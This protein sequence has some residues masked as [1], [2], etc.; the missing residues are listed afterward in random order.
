MAVVLLGIVRVKNEM[1]II[2]RVDVEE[3]P[4]TF[5]LAYED[6]SFLSRDDEIALKGWFFPV[7]DSYR[8]VILV[9]GV[10]LHRADPS[11]GMLNIA[12]GLVNFGFNVLTFDLR[13]HG[14]S[15]GN[16]RY[17]GH[18]EKRDLHG[19]IDYI[20]KRAFSKIGVL[21]F[22]MGAATA[23]MT[24]AESDDIDAIV[25]DS[26]FADVKDIIVAQFK[27][28]TGLPRFMMR[29]L[30]Q[31]ARLFYRINFLA[32]KPIESLAE[33]GDVPVFFIHG[34]QD[35]TIPVEHARRMYQVSGNTKNKL[36][37]TP[38]VKHMRSYASF[39]TEYLKKVTAFFDSNLS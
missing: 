6:V 9:H 33:I 8:V 10:D 16:S 39:N 18:F 23:I 14:Q 29:P 36:W 1:S 30:F 17:V 31:A 12:A 38:G 22:S 2:K 27:K 20:K 13:G 7:Y 26:S 19:A 21:G 35:E 34:D 32:I 24:A 5:G 11:I 4:A 25:S 3:N 37:I 15:G 28:R